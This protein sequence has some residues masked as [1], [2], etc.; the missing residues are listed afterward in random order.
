MIHS[1]EAAGRSAIQDFPYILWNPNVHCGV[2]KIPQLVRVRWIQSIRSHPTSLRFILKLSFQSF[3]LTCP[4][5]RTT[6]LGSTQP[7]TDTGTRNL[8]EGKGR[9][10]RKDDNLTATCVENVRASTSYNP[11]DFHSNGTVFSV[12]SVP[13]YK[14]DRWKISCW[15]VASR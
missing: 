4:S 7:L 9:P 2:R 13:S 6:A 3:Q 15:T 14:Q 12:Q 1:S 8:P 5:S 11:I 10:A